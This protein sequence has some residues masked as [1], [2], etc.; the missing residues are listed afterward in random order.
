MNAA[1]HDD[2]RQRYEQAFRALLWR[3]RP[4]HLQRGV[5]LL[6][7]RAE[8]H[9]DRAP[10]SSLHESYQQVYQ[11]ARSQTIQ[12]LLRRRQ[13]HR[14]LDF[15]LTSRS[16]RQTLSV[17]TEGMP[18]NPPHDGIDFYC[19]SGLGGLARWL[20]AAGYDARFWPYI[21]DSELI[22]LATGS[23]AIVLTTD[24]PLMSRSA[25]AWGVISALHVPMDLGK[26]RQFKFVRQRLTL[27]RKPARC[28]ECGGRLQSVGKE[29]VR[30]RI[31]PR[32]YPWID[33]YYECSRCGKLFWPGTHW[34]QV[35]RL[36]HCND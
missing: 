28:M 4:R 9:L 27:P 21:D 23:A 19:D 25:I 20:R 18:E 15:S 1:T 7:R 26:H 30:S 22:R 31:P 36:L 8:L 13:A 33:E 2:E 29:S 16:V 35:A 5:E 3:V 12:Y 32:T 17:L 6:Q 10:E 24:Q 34:Q 14:N 11:R